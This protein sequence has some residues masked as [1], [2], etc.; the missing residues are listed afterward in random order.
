MDKSFIEDA[1]CGLYCAACPSYQATA[2][3][4]YQEKGLPACKGCKSDTVTGEWC[5]ICNL[6]SCAREK[7]LDF[8]YEC[9]QYPCENL[10]NF[11]ED[12]LYPY[13]NEVYDY[14]KTIKE[15]GK[16]IWLT[17]M[18]KRWSCN[19]CGTMHDWWSMKCKPC[20]SKTNGYIQ[21]KN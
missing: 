5:K 8:C 1:Y 9:N 15:K 14:M 21:P 17:E 12:I 20:G 19:D 2:D 3:G 18:K 7:G 4:T 13:H 10:N 6:K 16:E 11:K